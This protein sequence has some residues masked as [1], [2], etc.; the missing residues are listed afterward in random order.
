MDDR[1][2]VAKIQEARSDR[3]RAM[4][5]VNE[6]LRYSQPLEPKVASGDTLG[7]DVSDQEDLFDT[8]LQDTVDDFGS[9][10]GHLFTPR[11][12][13]WVK[14]EPAGDLTEG[15]KRAIE[16]QVKLEID[17]LFAEIE[18]SDFYAAAGECYRDLAIGVMAIDISD[19]GE[20]SPF[21]CQHI[22]LSQLLLSRGP[23]GT[24]DGRFREWVRMT[25]A[26]L[27]VI[28]REIFNPPPE[29]ER[30]KGVTVIDG[31]IRD[32][33]DPYLECW[34]YVIVVNGKVEHKQKFDGAGSCG[35]IV[36]P[37]R[38]DV[39]TAWKPGPAHKA[40]PNARKLDELE[41]LYLKALNRDVDP[42]VSYEDDGTLNVEGGIDAGTWLPRAR[43][44]EAPQAIG[45][46]ARLDAAVFEREKIVRNIKRA[47]YQ[48]RPEQ[49]GQT[50]PTATQWLDEKAWN[51]R[52]ME[53]PR[54]MLTNEWVL[55]I[56][57][58]FTWLRAQRGQSFG[59]T[60]DKRLV[61]LRPVSPLS[62]A[63]DLEDVQ[64]TNQLVGMVNI[65]SQAEA[66]G[67]PID[68]RATVENIQRTLGEKHVVLKSAEQI[69]Q[70]TM[71]RLGGAEQGAPMQ[72]Q[73]A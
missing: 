72:E 58:R 21:R 2:I 5:W 34:H 37:W 40:L 48:D 71:M 11:H 67:S 45:S 29:I 39:R 8:T 22:G 65:L 25:R 53:L 19:P 27:P 3:S 55:P 49:P 57:N 62:K 41:Y 32:W 36:A 64:T 14:A 33:T 6:V 10:M 13:V 59:V 60:V 61:A 7:P 42:V 24:F 69:A 12:E 46:E 18:R 16:P 15:E 9:D 51:T 35:I 66:A 56:I 47:L 50:P 54:D 52:R 23:L 31:Y 20:P 28:W 26:D 43:G 38:K 4:A 70:E 30:K 44:S 63:R 73:A 68:A 1:Q 17:Q